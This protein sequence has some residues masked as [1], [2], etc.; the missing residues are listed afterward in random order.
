MPKKIWRPIIALVT[1]LM[2]HSIVDPVADC[3]VWTGA[4]K[5]GGYGTVRKNDGRRK[6][7]Y[8]AHRASYEEFVGPIPDGLEL[9]HLCRNRLCI[10]PSHLEPVTR[11]ENIRRGI[12]PQTVQAY[13]AR[14]THCRN[15][16]LLAGDNVSHQPGTKTGR[17]CR[18]CVR[19]YVTRKCIKLGLPPPKSKK[20]APR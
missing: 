13:H 12:G 3:W 10:N 2:N 15:G 17:R 4:R 7:S 5:T 20:V 8:S 9:D 6:F 14:R 11:S 18:A 16:H 1:K 19:D